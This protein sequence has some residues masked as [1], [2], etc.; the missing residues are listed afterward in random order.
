MRSMQVR[1]TDSIPWKN[2][3]SGTT[4]IASRSAE[5]ACAR[6]DL[7]RRVRDEASALPTALFIGRAE[8]DRC[9]RRTEAELLRQAE[10]SE[11]IS[12]PGVDLVR[13]EH[14]ASQ[15]RVGAAEPVLPRRTEHID[16]EGVLEC[17]R[18]MG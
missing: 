13:R 12:N 11:R 10:V 17:E 14:S 18:A 5:R 3:L 16:V 7:D 9:V 1:V 8:H 15:V 6:P 2:K 4:G